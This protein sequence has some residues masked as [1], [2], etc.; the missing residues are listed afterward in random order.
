VAWGL[1]VPSGCFLG[2]SWVP[3]GWLLGVSG[4]LLAASWA[5]PG[6]LLV[7]PPQDYLAACSRTANTPTVWGLTLESVVVSYPLFMLFLVLL[8]F[9]CWFVYFLCACLCF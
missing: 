6:W 7:N 3:P 2:A 4:C 5:C 1:W 9:M 8:L